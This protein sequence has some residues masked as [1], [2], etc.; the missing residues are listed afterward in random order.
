MLV[1][2]ARLILFV[3]HIVGRHNSGSLE[4]SCCIPDL[5]DSLDLSLFGGYIKRGFDDLANAFDL[6]GTLIRLGGQLGLL[7]SVLPLPH[8]RLHVATR[9]EHRYYTSASELFATVG[10]NWDML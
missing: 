9:H 3:D 10:I 4:R 2:M 1:R 6:D 5:S 8:L 7:R